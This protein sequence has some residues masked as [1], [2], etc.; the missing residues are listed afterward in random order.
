[1]PF[2]L[3]YDVIYLKALG[4]V[5]SPP[6]VFS[7]FVGDSI[8]LSFFEINSAQAFKRADDLSCSLVHRLLCL[9]NNKFG[10]V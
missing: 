9:D 2:N 5:E 3:L 6:S 7:P 8:H 4:F 10:S 1:M